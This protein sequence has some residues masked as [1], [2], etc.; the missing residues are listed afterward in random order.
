MQPHAAA[1]H[2]NKAGYACSP[3]QYYVRLVLVGCVFGMRPNKYGC[4]RKCQ[5][6]SITGTEHLSEPTRSIVKLDSTN[7]SG[8][9]YCLYTL[10]PCE[11]VMDDGAVDSHAHSTS[12][13][14]SLAHILKTLAEWVVNITNL[15]PY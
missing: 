4:I 6:C 13:T 2:R 7:N 15:R 11:P 8:S 12:S 5:R 14:S 10:W 9:L 3:A 1:A